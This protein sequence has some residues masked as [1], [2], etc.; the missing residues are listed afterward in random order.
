MWKCAGWRRF[1]SRLPTALRLYAV[2]SPVTADLFSLRLA[3][4]RGMKLY[5][6]DT[7]LYGNILRIVELFN[8]TAPLAASEGDVLYFSGCSVFFFFW[9]DCSATVGWSGRIFTKSSQ[10]DVLAV[11]FV[12]GGAPWKSVPRKFFGA[13]NVNFW[14]ENSHPAVFGR[15][16]RGNENDLRED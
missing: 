15:P 5:N 2:C 8:Y 1:R 12:N 9:R 16:L 3:T 7:L 4:A 14:S 13:Q 10:T 6:H 11:L